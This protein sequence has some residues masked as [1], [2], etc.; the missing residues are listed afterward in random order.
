MNSLGSYWIFISFLDFI[1]Q[2][3]FFF[4]TCFSMLSFQVIFTWQVKRRQ[5]R[6]PI[7]VALRRKCLGRIKRCK[8][9]AILEDI[10]HVSEMNICICYGFCMIGMVLLFGYAFPQWN[11][12]A[13]SLQDHGMTQ[14]QVATDVLIEH[15]FR[16]SISTVI[17]SFTNDCKDEWQFDC[18]HCYLGGWPCSS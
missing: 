14:W 16:C 17:P 8:D 13:K 18:T 3:F 7:A 1:P 5:Q 15:S 2:S 10:S 11:M 6:S 12:L 9:H 4:A